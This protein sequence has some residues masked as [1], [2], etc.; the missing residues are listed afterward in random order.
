MKSRK[1]WLC[2]VAALGLVWM[3]VR[4]APAREEREHMDASRQSAIDAEA[5]ANLAL[6][7]SQ[8]PVIAEWAAKGKPYIPWA[9]HAGDLPQAGIPAFPGAQG[10]GEYSFGGRDGKVMVVTNLNDS[11][12]G[13]YREALESAGPR[14]VVFAV[15]GIIHTQTPVEIRAPYITIVGNT[16]PGDGVCIAGPRTTDIDTHDVVIRY[17]RFRRGATDPTIR[18]HCLSGDGVGNIIVDH[19]SCSW[20]LDENLSLYKHIYYF[21]QFSAHSKFKKL[22][23]ANITIQWSITSEALN[24][25]DHAFGGT[26]GGTNDTFHHN[27]FCDDTGRNSS[28]GFGGDFNYVNNV[29]FN[30]RH[31]T[32]DGGDNTSRANIINNY[33]EPGPAVNKG[34]IECSCLSPIAGKIPAS[35][36]TENIM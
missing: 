35:A 27:L 12:P 11:G 5:N 36:S 15:A 8:Q 19:C 20:G 30:W 23:T 17:L 34:Q 9:C 6:W 3:A 1:N 7:K 22:P 29:V 13:S 32:V 31:R 16:A 26:W 25:Q 18:D 2:V 21:D 10:G 14:I 28:M 33:F 24:P 4:S